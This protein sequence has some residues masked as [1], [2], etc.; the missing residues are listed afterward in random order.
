M[1]ASTKTGRQPKQQSTKSKKRVE[2]FG[3]VFTPVKIVRQMLDMVQSENPGEDVFGIEKTWFEPCCGTGNFA[4]EI[5]SRKLDRC[6][7]GEDVRRAVGS[8]YTVEI[9]PDNAEEC[10]AR[11]AAL[12]GARFPWVQVRDIL[13]KNILCGDA[14]KGM[15]QLEQMEEWPEVWPDEA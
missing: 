8:Y 9:Q 12:V 2:K 15:K 1:A 7:T 6:L 11:I 3:E 4:V 14:L 13:D 5:I 10:K